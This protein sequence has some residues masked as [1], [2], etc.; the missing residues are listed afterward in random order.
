MIGEDELLKSG[1]PARIWQKYCGFLDLTLSEFMEIQEQLLMEQI[2]LV[3]G[4]PLAKKLMPKKPMDISEFRQIVPLTTYDDYTPHLTEQDESVLAVKP[5]RWAHTSGRRGTIKWVPYT[6]RV[7]ERFGMIGA[8]SMILACANKK[9]EVNFKS[10]LK[11]LTNLPPAP[12]MTGLLNELLAPRLGARLIPPTEKYRDADFATKIQAGF[13]IA[14][15][16]GID[17]LCSMASV[18]VKMGERFSESSGQLR[19]NRKMLH[20]QIMWRLTAAWLRSKRQGRAILPKDLWPLKGLCSFGM[21][22]G[23]YREQL[24]YYWGK[25]PFESYGATETG[26]LATHAWNKKNLTFVP[27]FCFLEFAPEEEWRK[28]G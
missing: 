9:G 24:K 15:R 23:I 17:V 7:I 10:G 21:D 28:S 14:L 4:S 25:E 26:L 8:A 27:W 12:Y 19:F 11:I 2:D 22:T 1:D 13:S 20:P 5:Y 18:L 3:H 6:E 16:S